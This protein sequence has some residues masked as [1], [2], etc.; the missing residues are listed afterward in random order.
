METKREKVLRELYRICSKVLPEHKNKTGHKWY[1]FPQLISMW[2]YGKIFNL[3]FR[4]IQE[5]F[6]TSEKLRKII[7]L[8][9]FQITQ[10]YAELLGN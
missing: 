2:L 6:K 9:K 7:G 8:K 10:Q 4:D 3:T 5:E 1:K